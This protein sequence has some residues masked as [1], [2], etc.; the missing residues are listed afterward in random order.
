MSTSCPLWGGQHT[1]CHP[2]FLPLLLKLGGELLLQNAGKSQCHEGKDCKGR[3]VSAPG[4][5]GEEVQ[6]DTQWATYIQTSDIKCTIA[7]P[8]PLRAYR[9]VKCSS[10]KYVRM[11]NMFIW[12][13]W[14]DLFDLQDTYVH[15]IM[16]AFPHTHHL[17][18]QPLIDT[19]IFRRTYKVRTHVHA[20][21]YNQTVP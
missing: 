14:L 13:D 3:T 2:P 16:C 12:L 1:F 4:L 6:P 18:S 5:A 8:L 17:H 21:H 11:Y 7:L 15:S 19:I 20:F 9:A 10:C